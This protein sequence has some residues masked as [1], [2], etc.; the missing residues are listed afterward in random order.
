MLI[1]HLQWRIEG[2]YQW[3]GDCGWWQEWYDF[4]CWFKKY[5]DVPKKDNIHESTRG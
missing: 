1:I 2:W 3:K 4:K 5:G